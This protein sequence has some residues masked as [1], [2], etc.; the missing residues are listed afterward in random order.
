MNKLTLYAAAVVA[1]GCFAKCTAFPVGV[2]P[3]QAQ[4]E[5]TEG[6]R[7]QLNNPGDFEQ[8]DNSRVVP[9]KLEPV[10]RQVNAD[11]SWMHPLQDKISRL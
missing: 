6:H 9:T 11:G 1:P 8:I 10:A 3:V 7:A 2:R 4:L 5:R